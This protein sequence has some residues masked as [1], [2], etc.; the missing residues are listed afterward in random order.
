MDNPEKKEGGRAPATVTRLP[1]DSNPSNTIAA[2]NAAIN[3]ETGKHS[4]SGTGVRI[5][6]HRPTEIWQATSRMGVHRLREK[7]R[8]SLAFWLKDAEKHSV[9]T[10][11][12]ITTGLMKSGL[13]YGDRIEAVHNMAYDLNECLRRLLCEVDRG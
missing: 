7:E 6:V 10:I 12:A 13:P 11:G 8:E 9:A 1:P 3:R 2:D 5:P 4:I